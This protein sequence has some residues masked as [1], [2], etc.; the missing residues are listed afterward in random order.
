MDK[1]LLAKGVEVLKNASESYENASTKVQAAIGALVIGLSGVASY[2]ISKSV[3]ESLNSGSSITEQL[4]N[5]NDDNVKVGA[6]KGEWTEE[7]VQLHPKLAEYQELLDEIKY[8]L[9][10]SESIDH[11][12]SS[13]VQQLTSGMEQSA[14]GLSN[15]ELMKVVP[16]TEVVLYNSLDDKELISDIL[17]MKYLEA[18]TNLR[19]KTNSDGEYNDNEA[20]LVEN[21]EYLAEID[22]YRGI[23]VECDVDKLLKNGE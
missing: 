5:K 23:Y 15:E 19:S 17:D 4:F 7:K 21:L 8:N 22:K 6:C 13:A 10:I 12:N 20:V 1:N 2:N 18:I 11:I 16:I 14:E 3:T 9:T